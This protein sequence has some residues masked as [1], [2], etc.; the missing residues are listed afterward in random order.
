MTKK[1][2]A[3][4]ALELFGT[5]TPELWT[6]TWAQTL[7]LSGAHALWHLG[8]NKVASN[9]FFAFQTWDP[10]FECCTS[11]MVSTKAS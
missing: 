5:K 10:C 9:N 2:P 3:P 4:P 8:L 11:A 1:H 6:A 7:T